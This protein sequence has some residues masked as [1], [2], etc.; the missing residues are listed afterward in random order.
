MPKSLEQRTKDLNEPAQVEG[1]WAVIRS[2]YQKDLDAPIFKRAGDITGQAKHYD[3]ASKAFIDAGHRKDDAKAGFADLV[4]QLND[5]LGKIGEMREEFQKIEEDEA[6]SQ[7]RTPSTG[8]VDDALA[9]WNETIKAQQDTNK[10]VKSVCDNLVKMYD[11]HLKTMIAG[12]DKVKKEVDTA[13]AALAKAN[14][15]MNTAEAQIRSTVVKYEKA[16][17]D[18]GKREIADGV[19]KLLIEFGK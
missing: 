10:T 6:A 16:A 9:G 12:R 19:R 4:K 7:K 13:N 8:S 3:A 5:Q 11:N 18:I 2:K 17:F 1:A 15:D 14:A